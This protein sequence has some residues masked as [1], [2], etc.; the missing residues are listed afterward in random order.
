VHKYHF[1]HSTAH[2]PTG[3]PEGDGS[4]EETARREVALKLGAMRAVAN[5]DRPCYV[6][7]RWAGTARYMH[8]LIWFN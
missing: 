8:T 4:V 6:K 7:G 1:H 3:V 2:F 5:Y